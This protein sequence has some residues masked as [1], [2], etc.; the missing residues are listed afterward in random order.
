MGMLAT[1][2]DDSLREAL[3]VAAERVA[4]LRP[5]LAAAQAT[6]DALHTEL[7]RWQSLALSLREVLGDEEPQPSDF[8]EGPAP[9][10]QAPSEEPTIRRVR[11]TEEVVTILSE[12]SRPLSRKEILDEFERKGLTAGMKNAANAVA[13]AVAR[14]VEKRRAIQVGD[15]FAAAP[16]PSASATEGSWSPKARSALGGAT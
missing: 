16:T 5:Q 13:T 3:N 1:M 10:P 11:S 4:V 7:A 15:A 2:A 12:A 8:T 6:V 14:A 9:A